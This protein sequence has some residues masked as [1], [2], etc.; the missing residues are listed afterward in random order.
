MDEEDMIND[1]VYDVH[2][3]NGISAMTPVQK[4]KVD[5]AQ[6]FTL[7]SLLEI[8]L[9]GPDKRSSQVHS[10]YSRCVARAVVSKTNN[11]SI[12]DLI[13]CRS[14]ELMRLSKELI[15]TRTSRASGI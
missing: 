13:E 4:I 12:A 5:T 3:V 10:I 2:N 15:S 14:Q 7:P 6:P 9:S 1:H 11:K 8:E